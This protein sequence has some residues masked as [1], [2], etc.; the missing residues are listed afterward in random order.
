MHHVKHI[1]SQQKTIYHT[2]NSKKQIQMFL[3]TYIH[4]VQFKFV[5]IVIVLQKFRGHEK[6]EK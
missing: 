5:K 4:V 2:N 6:N 3:K 1:V